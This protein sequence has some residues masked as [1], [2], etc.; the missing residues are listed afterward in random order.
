MREKGYFWAF[1][2]GQNVAFWALGLRRVCV[3]TRTLT[4]IQ[5]HPLTWSLVDQVDLNPH[6]YGFHVFYAFVLRFHSLFLCIL[7]YYLI[8][9]S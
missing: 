5:V 6:S 7:F 4:R 9:N 2:R 3:L 8:V 1:I